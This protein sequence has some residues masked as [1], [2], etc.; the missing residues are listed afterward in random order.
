MA[1]VIWSTVALLVPFTVW[2]V[3]DTYKMCTDSKHLQKRFDEK[4]NK[5]NGGS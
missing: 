4:F 1:Y 2:Y 3:W 5:Y